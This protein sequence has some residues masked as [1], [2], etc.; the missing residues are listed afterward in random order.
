MEFQ[1]TL[2]R[3]FLWGAW[4]LMARRSLLL[5]LLAALL[6]LPGIFMEPGRSHDD[7]MNAV[8]LTA[9]GFMTLFVGL[10]WWR[11]RESI[12]K[13]LDRQQGKPV[14]CSVSDEAISVVSQA[15]SGSLKWDM[16]HSLL[17]TATHVVPKLT[18]RS[19]AFTLPTEQVPAEAL[20]FIIQQ[21]QSH[22][23]PVRDRRK[24]S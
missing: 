2:S 22:G 7:T 17:V 20:D 5:L 8:G 21:F 3:K 15:G 19:A 14:E 24:K 1:V 11:Y 6:I 10:S 12:Q 13:S 9:L 18:Y 16:F 23:K 4:L